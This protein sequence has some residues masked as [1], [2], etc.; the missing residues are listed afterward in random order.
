MARWIAATAVLAA[1]PAARFAPVSAQAAPYAIPAVAAT[2][3]TVACNAPRQRHLLPNGTFEDAGP[4]DCYPDLHSAPMS[5]APPDMGNPPRP[6]C[7]NVQE[8]VLQS[9]GTF[10]TQLVQRCS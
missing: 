1:A 10:R 5:N 7:R 9:D 6:T 3:E 8:R 2:A 4:Q